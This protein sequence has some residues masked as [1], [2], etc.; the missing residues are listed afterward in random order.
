MFSPPFS[1]AYVEMRFI[2]AR[3][4]FN[5]NMRLDDSSKQWI[6]RQRAYPLWARIPLS[7]YLEPR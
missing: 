3:L 5:F 1:L 4:I 6:E 2:L 7:V